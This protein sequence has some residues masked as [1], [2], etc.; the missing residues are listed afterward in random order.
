MATRTG[1]YCD[2]PV[3]TLLDSLAGKSVV[4][5]VVE[6]NA[7]PCVDL[8]VQVLTGTQGS[9]DDGYLVLGAEVQVVFEPVVG[10]VNNLVDGKGAA[11]LSGFRAL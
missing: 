5:D 8:L 6:R 7:A 9:D 2:Q 3:G 11:G 4:D 1:S 10:T